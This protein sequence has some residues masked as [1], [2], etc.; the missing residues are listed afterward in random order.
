MNTSTELDPTGLLAAHL[1]IDPLDV[2][3]ATYGNNEWDAEGATYLVLTDDEADAAV[4]DYIRESV[5]AFNAEFLASETGLDAAVFE[6]LQPQCEGANAAILT[7]IE[8]LAEDGLEGFAAEAVRY[9]GRGHFLAQYDGEELELDDPD[10]HVV[11]YAY[12][13]N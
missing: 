2:T 1:D 3:E 9:D 4:I 10:G 11:A 7:L 12:R 6:A 5:W 8:K 13:T